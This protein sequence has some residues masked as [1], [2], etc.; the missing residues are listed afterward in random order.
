MAASVD[1][2]ALA[3]ALVALATA[4]NRRAS[5]AGRGATLCRFSARFRPLFRRSGQS[6]PSARFQSAGDARR[7]SRESAAPRGREVPGGC[8]PRVVLPTI[9]P[10]SVPESSVRGRD[11]AAP[12]PRP[13][14]FHRAN[15]RSAR[16]PCSATG[17][18]IYDADQPTP[19]SGRLSIPV[20]ASRHHGQMSSRRQESNNSGAQGIV[21]NAFAPMVLTCFGTLR[22]PIQLFP[23]R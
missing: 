18:W 14:R 4:T 6:D 9:A 17:R 12:F 13:A 16:I 11:C 5:P 21:L 19:E 20:F 1:A 22:A 3:D 8:G 7:S 23:I 10:E 2:H 15:R